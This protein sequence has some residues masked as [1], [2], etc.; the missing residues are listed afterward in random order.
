M[1]LPKEMVAYLII[2]LENAE[3]EIKNG[4]TKKSFRK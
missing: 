3:K 4:E 2:C 1:L